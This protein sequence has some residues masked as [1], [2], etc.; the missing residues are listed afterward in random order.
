MVLYAKSIY[1]NGYTFPT[2][3]MPQELTQVTSKTLSATIMCTSPTTTALS[4]WDSCP[5]VRLQRRHVTDNFRHPSAHIYGISSTPIGR[6]ADDILS[7]Y[8]VQTQQLLIMMMVDCVLRGDLTSPTHTCRASTNLYSNQTRS[9]A[10]IPLWR[11]IVLPSPGLHCPLGVADQ[12]MHHILT[13]MSRVKV[14]KKECPSLHPWLSI[15][16]PKHRK[17]QLP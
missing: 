14:E 16:L 10:G 13:Y 3:R 11:A 6:T 12:S 9:L 1:A 2:I 15:R 5:D 7:W 8:T 17:I 4:W